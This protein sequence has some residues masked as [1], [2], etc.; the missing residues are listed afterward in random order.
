MSYTVLSNKNVVARKDYHSDSFYAFEHIIGVD[1]NKNPVVDVSEADG[2]TKDEIDLI[3]SCIDDNWIIK[4][5][6]L[7][8]CQT[9]VYE[10]EMYT[11]RSRIGVHDIC[12]RHNL[13]L[14]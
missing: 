5:G 2:Y 11:A 6:E 7:H 1:E 8:Y 4:K 14:D 10:G 9:G 3:Q 12:V 13:F